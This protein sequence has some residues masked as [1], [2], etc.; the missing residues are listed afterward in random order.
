MLQSRFWR[1]D[2]GFAS[3]AVCR[4]IKSLFKLE[5][6]ATEQESRAAAV[7]ATHRA[8]GLFLDQL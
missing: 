7:Q 6:P 3:E 8:R 1:V 2:V 4:N 5:P